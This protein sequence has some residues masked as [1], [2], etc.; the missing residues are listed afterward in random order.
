M[1]IRLQN[2][3][4]TWANMHIISTLK[5]F[6]TLMPM[7]YIINPSG[8]NAMCSGTVKLILLPVF[9]PAYVSFPFER[10]VWKFLRSLFGFPLRWMYNY[11]ENLLPVSFTVH[12]PTVLKKHTYIYH[13]PEVK[14]SHWLTDWLSHWLTDCLTDCLTDWLTDCLTDWLTDQQ[15]Y[16]TNPV[17][18]PCQNNTFNSLTIYKH[19][20]ANRLTPVVI[21]PMVAIWSLLL[22]LSG[23]FSFRGWRLPWGRAAVLLRQRGV[24]QLWLW[25]QEHPTGVHQK[26]ETGEGTGLH[27]W[28]QYDMLSVEWME[29][30]ETK[31][32]YQL[33]VIQI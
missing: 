33:L 15:L 5:C 13:P 12:Q 17:N 3:P 16:R 26:G 23:V 21:K 4:K 27:E 2:C 1:A 28:E 25:G 14:L 9:T 6:V 32:F 20:I 7:S 19:L 10:Q 30:I 31:P 11:P 18:D 24:Y 22:L 8:P 29:E